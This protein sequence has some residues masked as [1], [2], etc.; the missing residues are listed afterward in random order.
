MTETSNNDMKH[1]ERVIMVS[2]VLKLVIHVTNMSGL[3]ADT[4]Q[5]V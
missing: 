1:K 4:I 5:I 2:M 3:C